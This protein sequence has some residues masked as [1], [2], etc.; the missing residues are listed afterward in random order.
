MPI[1]GKRQC[2]SIKVPGVPSFDTAT[3]FLIFQPIEPWWLN[4]V[5]PAVTA[6]WDHFWRDDDFQQAY[7]A[8]LLE[9]VRRFKD[10]PAL[11]GYDLMNEPYQG[12]LNVGEFER[13]I[14]TLTYQEWISAIRTEDNENW[15]FY[16]PVSWIVNTSLIP[17]KIGV[18]AEDRAVYFPHLYLFTNDLNLP[19]NGDPAFLFTWEGRAL[20][21]V[22]QQK[23][24]GMNVRHS[25]GG[26]AQGPRISLCLLH[27]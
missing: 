21:I 27:Q 6:S 17:S 22:E 11:I 5:Q 24:P 23:A 10:H 12:S 3:L 7:T 13:T 2:L 1:Y 25:H 8:M 14:L 15:I 9:Y 19:W 4:N 16:E 26:S 20:Q 18:L